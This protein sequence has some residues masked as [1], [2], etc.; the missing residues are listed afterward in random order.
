[1]V[2]GRF[3]RF[4]SFFEE[5]SREE[6]EVEPIQ[7][8]LGL[9]SAVHDAQS[10]WLRRRSW[11]RRCR[12]RCSSWLRLFLEINWQQ[13]FTCNAES[14]SFY[15]QLL[16]VHLKETS[17]ASEVRAQL[18]T[19]P[20]PQRPGSIDRG[21]YVRGRHGTVLPTQPMTSLVLE[22]EVSRSN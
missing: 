12:V 21:S 18:T 16:F 5:V 14:C 10:D 3:R 17:C 6:P 13:R 20:V 15:F 22:V 2:M 11:W 8:V 19:G 4:P 1:M 7:I 9:Q